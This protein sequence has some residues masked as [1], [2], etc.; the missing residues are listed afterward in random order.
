MRVDVDVIVGV[1][2]SVGKGVSVG[3]AE[4]VLVAVGVHI[5]AVAVS[6]VD[7]MV[8]CCSAEGLHA[9]RNKNGTMSKM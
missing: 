4:G 9:V 5:A 8:A 2:V 1:G 3:V 6:A 7:T